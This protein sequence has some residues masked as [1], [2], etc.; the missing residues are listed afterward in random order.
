MPCAKLIGKRPRHSMKNVIAI[1]LK[2]VAMLTKRY[3]LTCTGYIQK[4]YAHSSFLMIDY[5]LTRCAGYRIPRKCPC[6]SFQK[7]PAY[8]LRDHW[9]RTPLKKWKRPR[10]QGSQKLAA[11]VW[12]YIPRVQHFWGEVRL[13]GWRSWY[14]RDLASTSSTGNQGAA[15]CCTCRWKDTSTEAGRSRCLSGI[16]RC[17][18]DHNLT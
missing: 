14:R 18:N 2:A 7:G 3:M 15:A 1:L 9:D 6:F 13:H 5:G 17:A 12:L 8:H 11:G 10:R 16:Y 4:R